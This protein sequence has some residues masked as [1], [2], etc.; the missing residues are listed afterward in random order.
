MF[1]I[2]QVLKQF[3]PSISEL[4]TTLILLQELS[5]PVVTASSFA[6][7]HT[8]IHNWLIL[9]KWTIETSGPLDWN[10]QQGPCV[11]NNALQFSCHSCFHL[12]QPLYHPNWCILFHPIH[13]H[14]GNGHHS[15]PVTAHNRH[16]GI[17]T[18]RICIAGRPW[19]ETKGERW[20]RPWGRAAFGRWLNWH[21]VIYD[22]DEQ[23]DLQDLESWHQN[24][25]PPWK[26]SQIMKLHHLILGD[27]GVISRTYHN[28]RVCVAQ[29]T[30]PLLLFT[31]CDLASPMDIQSVQR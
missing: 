9:G 30:H 19:S 20:G 4:L 7:L 24:W 14:I 25:I 22:C 10:C 16:F 1:M 6:S 11:I 31:K 28:L 12:V 8:N 21:G 27:K 15:E 2:P 29:W 5:K 23:R 18:P 17:E 26:Q 3:T 13:P